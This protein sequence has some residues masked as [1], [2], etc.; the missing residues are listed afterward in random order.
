MLNKSVKIIRAVLLLYLKH[1]VA[2]VNNE[3]YTAVLSATINF[4]ETPEMY[5]ERELKR[6]IRAHSPTYLR[7]LKLTL[8]SLG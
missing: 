6:V 3:H 8:A 7:E 2:T 1:K 5:M 4:D